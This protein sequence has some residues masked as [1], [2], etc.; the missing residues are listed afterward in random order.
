MVYISLSS[1]PSKCVRALVCIYI[2]IGACVNIWCMYRNASFPSMC[3]RV[4]VCIYMY[5][6]VCIYI[7]GVCVVMIFISTEWCIHI[8]KVCTHTYDKEDG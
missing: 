3:V 7:N 2:Q 8:Y 4:L 5:K 6:S 1:P